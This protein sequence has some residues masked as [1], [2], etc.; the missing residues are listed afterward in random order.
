LG[1]D[2]AARFCVARKATAQVV[3]VALKRQTWRNGQEERRTTPDS[4]RGDDGRFIDADWSRSRQRLIVTVRRGND[5][6]RAQQV[7]LTPDQ[8]QEFAA[9]LVAGPHGP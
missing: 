7:L 5:Y 8:V 1:R 9:F 4:D 3:P 2:R 6:D